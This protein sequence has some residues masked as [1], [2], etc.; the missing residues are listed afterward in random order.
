[1]TAPTPHSPRAIPMSGARID[2]GSGRILGFSVPEGDATLFDVV[3]LLVDGQCLVSAVANLAALARA[4]RLCTAHPA[5]QPA[6]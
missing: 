4:K 2:W 6:A 1:M 3:Q 5:S